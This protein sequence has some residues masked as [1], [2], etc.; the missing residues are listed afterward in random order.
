VKL[1]NNLHLVLSLKISDH[2]LQI[3][4]GIF[5]EQRGNGAP[6]Y[7]HGLGNITHIRKGIVLFVVIGMLEQNLLDLDFGW[8]LAG[9]YVVTD[10]QTDGLE[11]KEVIDPTAAVFFPHTTHSRSHPHTNR[12]TLAV[13]SNVCME[14]MDRPVTLSL[15]VSGVWKIIGHEIGN[16]TRTSA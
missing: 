14:N 13:T 6:L 11:G 1:T 10:G 3:N 5:C 8:S 7:G 12:F 9:I 16:S 15:Q 4:V 2:L